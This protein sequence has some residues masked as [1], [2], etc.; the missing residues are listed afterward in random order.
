MGLLLALAVALPSQAS[1]AR[2]VYV[3]AYDGRSVSAFSMSG[4]GQLASIATPYDTGVDTQGIAISPDGRY[5]YAALW[6]GDA[7]RGYRVEQGGKLTAIGNTAAETAPVGLAVSPD[8]RLLAVTNY[9]SSDISLYRI[10]PNGGLSEH[11]VS[12]F[13]TGGTNPFG[14]TFSPDGRHLYVAFLT[15]AGDVGAFAVAA[16]DS[17]GALAGSPY[18]VGIST[19]S[20][21]AVTPDGR[22][23]YVSHQAVA[24]VAG[25]SIAAS[26]IPT[27]LAGSPF[28]VAGTSVGIGVDPGGE[29]L[30]LKGGIGVMG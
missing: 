13:S 25:L 26:G 29:F 6:G 21:V 14:V 12:P 7:V 10:G 4:S 15:G 5:L 17:L 3:S 30:Y 24:N 16:D 23:L 2:S 27:P 28:P 19:A 22:F 8:G 18:D 11:P 1:A 20:G 9:F